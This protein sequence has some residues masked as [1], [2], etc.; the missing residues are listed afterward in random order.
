V[1]SVYVEPPLVQP[2]PVVVEWGPPPMLVEPPPPAPFIG[3]VWVGGYWVWQGNW[4]WATGRWVAPPYAGYTWVHPYYEHREGV[5]V[6][7]SGHWAAPGVV[8]VPPPPT[9]SLRVAAV[10]PGVVRGPRPMGPPGVFVPAPPGSRSG[11]IVPA[12]IGTAPAVVVGAPAVANVGMRIQNRVDNNTTIVNSR[13]TNVTNITN[14]TIVAPAGATAS[15]HAFEAQVP[16]AAHL[17]AAQRPM[18]NAAAPSPASARPIPAS[19][20]SRPMS[21]ASS[22]AVSQRDETGRP[23]GPPSTQAQPASVTSRGEPPMKDAG[24]AGRDA[25]AQRRIEA[26]RDRASHDEMRREAEAR[27]RA[28]EEKEREREKAGKVKREE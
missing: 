16:T 18:F 27:R 23:A 19:T 20:D 13:V 17:A 8:F 9:M 22:Q 2:A 1:V 24:A 10:A 3:A 25:E 15:G 7:V 14:V 5:V 28:E 6:F 4:V 26:E 11:L 12:P 21:P